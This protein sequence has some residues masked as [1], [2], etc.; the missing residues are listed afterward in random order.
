MTLRVA[1]VGTGR[2][3]QL[4]LARSTYSDAATWLFGRCA[5]STTGPLRP[6][7]I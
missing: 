6:P 1:I 5:M 7:A 2:R 4:Y 3:G